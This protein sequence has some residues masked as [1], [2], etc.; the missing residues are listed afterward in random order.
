MVGPGAKRDS[1]TKTGLPRPDTPVDVFEGKEIRFVQQA[2]SFESSA[3]EHEN[4]AR[5]R[6]DGNDALFVARRL[7]VALESNAAPAQVD[8]HASRLDSTVLLTKDHRPDRRK[9]RILDGVGKEPEAMGLQHRVAIEK[10]QSVA[11]LREKLLQSLV[12]PSGETPVLR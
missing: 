7:S 4:R 11:A 6:G 10:E 3:V 12:H 1:E 2:D 9:C 8:A 5:E